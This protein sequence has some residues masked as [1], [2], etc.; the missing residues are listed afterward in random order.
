V[1]DANSDV[2]TAMVPAVLICWGS[3]G[4]KEKAA[5]QGHSKTVPVCQLMQ[6]AGRLIQKP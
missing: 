2:F 5:S 1:W 4:E 6:G 3:A